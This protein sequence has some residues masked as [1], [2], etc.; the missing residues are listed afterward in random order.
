VLLTEA[1]LAT[2]R[3]ERPVRLLLPRPERVTHPARGTP[4]PGRRGKRPEVSAEFDALGQRL[5]EALRAHR[6]ALARSEGVPPYLIASDRCL[7]D[8]C[9]L[10]PRDRQTLLTAHGIGP[11]K[12]ERYGAGFLEVVATVCGPPS[13]V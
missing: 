3:G 10:R 13:G 8:L 5:F 4:T 7:R 11:V 6:L 2:M 1:G 12:A 9:L